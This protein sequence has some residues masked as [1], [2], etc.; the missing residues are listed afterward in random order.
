MPIGTSP[1]PTDSRLLKKHH[2]IATERR[3]E[4]DLKRD[5][6][7]CLK[8]TVTH[9]RARIY[10]I[11]TLRN[12]LLD[13]HIRAPLSHPH[14]CYKILLTFV[15]YCITAGTF[16]LCYSKSEGNSTMFQCPLI[17]STAVTRSSILTG[18]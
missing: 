17:T 6:I 9:S 10:D 16:R 18:L 14:V 5:S 8:D 4:S 12:S 13:T 1:D 2:W 3:T 15:T 7:Q 11:V